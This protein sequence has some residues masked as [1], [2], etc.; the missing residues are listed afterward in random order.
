MNPRRKPTGRRP[1][2]R[3]RGSAEP[4]TGE[5]TPAK[6]NN[7]P[8]IIGSCVG[9]SILLLIII[10]AVAGGG[11]SEPPRE[12]A[13]VEPEVTKEDPGVD[14]SDLVRK[15]KVHCEKGFNMYRA[16]LPD[17]NRRDRMSP[18]EREALRKKLEAANDE[19]GEGITYY[20]RANQLSGRRFD[21]TRYMKARR[22]LRPVL[23]ELTPRKH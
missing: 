5:Q 8:L 2:T 1:K 11:G 22:E 23:G 16:L 14:V 6:K 9:G 20:D 18:R 19:I 12:P 4:R 17:V 13:P 21:V 7:T 10:I 3:L 15:G